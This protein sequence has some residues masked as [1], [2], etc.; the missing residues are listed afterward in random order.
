M[1]RQWAKGAGDG[2]STSER[3]K[4][5]WEPRIKRQA[6]GAAVRREPQ[7]SNPDAAT[8]Y[9]RRQ[10]VLFSSIIPCDSRESIDRFSAQMPYHLLP[11]GVYQGSGRQGER[12]LILNRVLCLYNHGRTWF[13][14]VHH[15]WG[16]G[17][18]TEGK[19]SPH[20]LSQTLTRVQKAKE[21][22]F[23]NWDGQGHRTSSERSER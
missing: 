13:W 21:N 23:V 17:I 15:A 6:R 12:N 8:S 1:G 3:G 4:V 11:R 2:E 19:G 22:P 20:V 7:R 18:P 5:A 10:P 16:Q 9:N 14:N